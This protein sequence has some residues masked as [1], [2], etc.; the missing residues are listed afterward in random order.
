MAYP[1]K[2]YQASPAY[3][4]TDGY[5]LFEGVLEVGRMYTM[6]ELTQ[7]SPGAY[8]WALHKYDANNTDYGV[9]DLPVG[10]VVANGTRILI[11]ANRT[12]TNLGQGQW[13][14]VTVEFIVTI[15]TP[16]SSP[17]A[18]ET[19]TMLTVP[20]AGIEV[21]ISEIRAL[22]VAP[23]VGP[24]V[25]GF[26]TYSRVEEWNDP[27]KYY[28]TWTWYGNTGGQFDG[29]K[30]QLLQ[31]PVF[32]DNAWTGNVITEQYWPDTT[33]KSLGIGHQPADAT[34]RIQISRSLDGTAISNLITYGTGSGPYVPPPAPYVTI[35]N[36]ARVLNKGSYTFTVFYESN[37]YVA[38]DYYIIE[39][40]VGAGWVG[41]GSDVY[42][43]A[44]NGTISSQPVTPVSYRARLIKSNLSPD[45]ISNTISFA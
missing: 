39:R 33:W 23:D 29:D 3:Y 10:V 6:P 28:T 13:A 16:S 24:Y 44:T 8:Y 30:Y 20:A 37:N 25:Y 34:Y 45:V 18:E 14:W 26:N 22:L 42:Y 35:T 2:E 41:A 4:M 43:P 12:Y 31:D 17:G 5:P 9:L 11:T 32:I 40:D 36:D 38:G 1:P 7:H 15:I 19:S 27:G 21:T